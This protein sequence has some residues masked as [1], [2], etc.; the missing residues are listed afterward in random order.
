LAGPLVTVMRT[1]G[2]SHSWRSLIPP[3]G[4]LGS[5]RARWRPPEVFR[6]PKALAL[7]RACSPRA[8]SGVRNR[9]L[10]AL[11]GGADCI[12]EAL[13]LERQATWISRPQRSVR[14]GEGDE[15]HRRRRRADRR[16]DRPLARSLA[17]PPPGRPGRRSSAPS[18]AVTLTPHT[19]AT[20]SRVARRAG[21]P[22]RVHAHRLRHAYA[23]ELPREHTPITVIRDA[24]RP[25]QPRLHRPVSARS[26]A[27]A[28]VRHDAGAQPGGTE[29]SRALTPPRMPVNSSP[30]SRLVVSR[31]Q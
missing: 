24:L 19:F 16:A 6:E 20:C 11:L 3:G 28:C 10:I 26:R 18:R 21:I 23:S 7:I 25:L 29:G 22:R 12:S 8:P 27:D 30:G 9:A 1:N 13:A 31:L 5:R 14:H 2:P 15:P 4:P 17:R